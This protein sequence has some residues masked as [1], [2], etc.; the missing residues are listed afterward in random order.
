MVRDKASLDKREAKA[1]ASLWRRQKK[2]EDDAAARIKDAKQAFAEDL[3]QKLRLQEKR[4]TDKRDEFLDRI[5]AQ[6]EE[7]ERAGRLLKS[8]RQAKELAEGKV[9]ALEKDLGDPQLQLGQAMSLAE[10][11]RS[12]ARDGRVMT[13]QRRKILQD[14]VK[15]ANSLGGNLRIET[16][17]FPRGGEAD[18]ASYSW[19]FGE[20]L[21]KLEKLPQIVDQRVLDD[22]RELLSTA[23]GRIFSHLEG[24]FPNFVFERVTG[25]VRI[26]DRAIE[27]ASLYAKKFDPVTIDEG[28]DDSEA[29]AEGDVVGKGRAT[30]GAGTSGGAES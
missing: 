11:A 21:S 23:V 25:P 22:S 29:D 30:D 19:F 6:N 17:S 1:N 13:K 5:K 27:A 28:D 18:E 20:F 24:F 12:N 14:L 2:V 4:F 10:S 16:P 3:S 26:S 15:R 8:M 7:M 9:A